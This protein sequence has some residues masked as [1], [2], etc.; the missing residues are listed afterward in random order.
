[1]TRG[2]NRNLKSVPIGNRS[3][4]SQPYGARPSLRSIYSDGSQLIQMH[5]Q[6]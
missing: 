1:M 5:G 2:K 4:I 3:G 6:L